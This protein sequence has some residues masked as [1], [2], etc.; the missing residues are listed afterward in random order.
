[1]K[2]KKTLAFAVMGLLLMS[3][4]AYAM[5][6]PA[7]VY[8]ETMGYELADEIC[9]LP[10]GVTCDQWD[11]LK[12]KCGADYSYCKKKGYEIKT[13]EDS[14]KCASIMDQSCGVCVL[15]D[16]QETEITKL[17]ALDT[18]EGV[19][20]DGKC[21]L[22]ENA[23]NCPQDC[24]SGTRDGAC[25]ALKDDRC[26]PDC[27]EQGTPEKDPDCSQAPTTTET[28]PT[29]TIELTT[30]TT[31]QETTT[32]MIELPTTIEP[33]STVEEETPTTTETSASTTSTENAAKPSADGKGMDLMGLLPI[34]AVVLVVLVIMIA[35]F[36]VLRKK[37]EDAD[38][39]K[40]RQ[41]FLKWKQEQEKAGK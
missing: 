6:N 9:K 30:S 7:A 25:D 41:E 35:A 20:G 3:A 21:V 17:M 33:V 27:T 5:K 40:K 2:T 31:I 24:P 14:A 11:F 8:C 34:V 28:A 13:V 39:E 29:S 12:G 32:T 10:G 22:G 4:A 26:D 1:M 16:G 23:Q 36:Y 18:R 37:K 38:I 15:S 19:C